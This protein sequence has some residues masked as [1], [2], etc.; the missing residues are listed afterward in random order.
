MTV[1]Q[2]QGADGKGNLLLKVDKGDETFIL[3]LYRR[4]WPLW[5]EHIEP[6]TAKI[7]QKKMGT[8]VR[9][10]FQTERENLAMWT[11]EGFDVPQNFDY[12][13]PEGIDPPALW[14]E[15]C[16]GRLLSEVLRDNRLPWNEKE[17]VLTRFGAELGRRHLRFMEISEPSLVQIHATVGHILLYK[18][19]MI[20]FDL[21]QRF[22]PA[23]PPLEALAHELS[24]YLRSIAKNTGVR[25]N[26]AMHCLIKG[27]P[28][29]DLLRKTAEHGAYGRGLYRRIKRF[30][31]RRKRPVNGK[32]EVLLRLLALL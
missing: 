1:L 20:T 15:Y 31:D 18:N 32:T 3:K 21:E 17:Q 4:R 29:I 10:R 13:I 14:L 22:L 24:G 28:S 8:N 27:Y 9:I 11:R 2:G 6:V 23:L 7:F 5:K 25:F 26:D 16:P 12:P 30:K 19:R